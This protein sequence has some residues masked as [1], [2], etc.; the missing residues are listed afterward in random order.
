MLQANS[1]EIARFLRAWHENGRADFER[2]TPNLDYDEYDPKTAHDRRKWVALDRGQESTRSGAYLVSKATGAVYNIKAYGRPNH[3]VGN[4]V[5]MAR[6]FEK[7]TEDNR[8]REVQSAPL[9]PIMPTKPPRMAYEMAKYVSD[10]IRQRAIQEAAGQQEPGGRGK[11]TSIYTDQISV[12]QE[13]MHLMYE[14][15]ERYTLIVTRD[16]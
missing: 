3:C 15:G 13:S 8:K 14:N 12:R 10:L 5:M 7:A 6:A 2:R 4:V 9:V 11:L 1:P 16:D